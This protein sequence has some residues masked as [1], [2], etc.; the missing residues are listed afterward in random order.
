MSVAEEVG[1]DES[2]TN[3][4]NVKAHLIYSRG[5][6]GGMALMEEGLHRSEQ[7]GDHWGE[8]RALSNM[9][10]M[11]GDVRDVAR[12]ADFAQRP[13]IR[14]PVTRFDRSRLMVRRCSPSSCRGRGDWA[15]AE[16]ASST[17][18]EQQQPQA[19]SE[20]HSWTGVE[21][22]LGAGRER[23]GITPPD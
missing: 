2:V 23:P 22:C 19:G 20:G 10:G 21:E 11:Y 15:A 1:D 18:S 3:V 9:A 17:T 7:A 6:M 12:A 13:A 14:Q 4:L 5:D 16:N 8:V